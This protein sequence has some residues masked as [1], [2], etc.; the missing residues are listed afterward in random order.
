MAALVLISPNTLLNWRGVS[1]EERGD[2]SGDRGRLLVPSVAPALLQRPLQRA[3]CAKGLPRE[4]QKCGYCDLEVLVSLLPRLPRVLYGAGLQ[5]AAE[6]GDGVVRT[7]RSLGCSTPLASAELGE[8]LA[9]LPR[10]GLSPF[11]LGGAALSIS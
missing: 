10:T 3:E 4:S 8:N 1:A 5:G 7:A 6:D 11:F 9:P 2:A